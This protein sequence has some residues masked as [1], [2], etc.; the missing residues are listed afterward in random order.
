[1]DALVVRTFLV[2]A[3]TILIGDRIWWPSRVPRG[4]RPSA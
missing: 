1:M 4:S 3:L 2:P